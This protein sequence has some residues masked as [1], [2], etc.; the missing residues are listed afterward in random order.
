M[1]VNQPQIFLVED[2]PTLSDIF[3]D[4]FEINGYNIAY[5]ADGQSAIEYLQCSKP[6]LILLDLHLPIMS[7]QTLLQHIRQQKHLDHTHIVLLT[8]DGI[9]ARALAPQVDQ[10]ILKPVRYEVLIKLAQ[11]LGVETA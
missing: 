7:G 10:V 6:K 3:I 9:R 2:D 11:S 1:N 8:A 5:A 4:V